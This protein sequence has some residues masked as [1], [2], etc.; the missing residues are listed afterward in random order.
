MLHKYPAN[1]DDQGFRCQVSGVN[2]PAASGQERDAPLGLALLYAVT[3]DFFH[4]SGSVQL[5]ELGG[6]IF[7]PFGLFQR[8]KNQGL[9]KLGDCAVQTNAII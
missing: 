5:K 6:L 1:H 4:Q 3:F 8:L 2:R 7:H 9:L